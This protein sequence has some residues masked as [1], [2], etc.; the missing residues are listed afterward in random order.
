MYNKLLNIMSNKSKGKQK[1]ENDK[2]KG[3]DNIFK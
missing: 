1:G 2:G 3:D